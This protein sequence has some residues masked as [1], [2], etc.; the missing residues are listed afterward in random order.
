MLGMGADI[1]VRRWHPPAQRSGDLVALRT[2]LDPATETLRLLL[3]G[4]IADDDG[5]LL[6]PL[7]RIGASAGFPEGHEDLR[8]V[9]LLGVRVA[10]RVSHEEPRL[11]RRVRVVEECS[12]L[13]EDTE[14]RHREGTEL[15]LEPDEAGDGGFDHR[16][17]RPRPLI[18][19]R[20]LRDPAQD[21]EQEGPGRRIGDG[22]IRRGEPLRQGEA[23][24]GAQRLV[25]QADRG[26]G[27]LGRGVVGARLLAKSANRD[28]RPSGAV[29][30][31]SGGLH[32][33]LQPDD[34]AFELA[35]APEAESVAVR[36]DE[37]REDLELRPL[38]LNKAEIAVLEG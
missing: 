13:R 17:H 33:A 28:T 26:P 16:G 24:P 27:H 12:Q 19:R 21:T 36:V 30:L 32:V 11:G 25:D 18:G 2:A 9:F 37:V 4:R 35:I 10:E 29:N 34:I 38:L 7:D 6:L 1:P 22:D 5:D 14:L 8:Q 31:P 3:V 15:H 23:L 20:R